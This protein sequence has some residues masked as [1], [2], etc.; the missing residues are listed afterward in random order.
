LRRKVSV[1]IG[2]GV[3]AVVVVLIVMQYYAL[4]NLQELQFSPR[5]VGN[6]DKDTLS[7]DVEIDACNPT[8]FPT[9]FDQI[10]FELSNLHNNLRDAP[11][12]KEF[13]NMTL[14]G[15]VLMPMEASTLRGKIRIN[16]DTIP[17]E[18]W[19]NTYKSFTSLNPDT[20]NL[21]VTVETKVLGFIPLSVN[22]DFNYWEFVALL[23]SP[24]AA[25]FSCA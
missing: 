18:N 5:S 3:A 23:I 14:Q 15:E 8:P 25:E 1:S 12:M 11:E 9:G 16:T 6:F 2:V 13:A 7:L 17:L 21:K 22:K 24:R 19:W 4:N 20:I 10:Q